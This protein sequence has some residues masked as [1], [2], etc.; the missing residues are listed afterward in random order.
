MLLRGTVLHVD[1]VGVGGYV[2]T[3]GKIRRLI[4]LGLY[5]HGSSQG[6]F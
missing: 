4:E 2:D 1:S 3:V 6:A 5:E